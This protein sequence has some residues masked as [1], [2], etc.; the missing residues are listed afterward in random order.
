MHLYG[1]LHFCAGK[2]AQT[3]SLFH[4]S[5]WT[6]EGHPVCHIYLVSP[7]FGRACSILAAQEAES[8]RN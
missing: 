1:D 3:R 8:L 7:D 2:I 6:A 4:L 5:L